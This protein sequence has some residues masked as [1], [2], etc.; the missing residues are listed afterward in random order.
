M[1]TFFV[2]LAVL[3]IVPQW[4][5]ETRLPLLGPHA[6]LTATRVTLD[7]I[8]PARRKVGQL[9]FLGG[10]HLTSGDP[11]FGG[12]S[13]LSIAGD[14]FML[15]SDGGN[16]VRFRMGADWRPHTIWSGYLPGGPGSGW[17]KADRDSESMTTDGRH[18]WVGFER[19]N[20]IW[21]YT[22]DFARAEGRVKPAPMRKWP[23][24]GGAEAMTELPDGRFAVISEVAHVPPRYWAGSD[25]ARLRTRIGLLFAGDPLRHPDPRRF[26]YVAQG[27]Y[28]VSDATALPN[29]D[30]LV[31]N[32]KFDLPFRFVTMV[33]RVKAADVAPG[34]IARPEPLAVLDAPLIH[35]NFEGIAVT[36]QGDATILWIVSDDNESVLQRTLLLK[37]RLDG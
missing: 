19:A 10:V 28:D 8:N 36:R 16:V 33:S 35:D 6:K 26:A 25:E 30:L 34:K 1:R 24:N 20:A 4:A 5:G 37:F 11:A 22:A 32:R 7:P 9:T 18:V 31:L 17:E 13:S 23:T 29:G 12:Y 15:L 2:I 21:R 3:L 27:R 14:R